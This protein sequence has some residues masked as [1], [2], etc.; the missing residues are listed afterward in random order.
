MALSRAQVANISLQT[1]MQVYFILF[2]GL[3]HS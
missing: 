3:Q 1:F 2:W